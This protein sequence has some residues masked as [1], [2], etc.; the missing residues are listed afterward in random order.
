MVSIGVV[1]LGPMGRAIAYYLVR[2]T[3][4]VV[5][6]YD[7]SDEAINE[8]RRLALTMPLRLI[9]VIMRI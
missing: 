1:G 7:I 9:S 4:H 3:G 8:A 6:G 5:N 2:H